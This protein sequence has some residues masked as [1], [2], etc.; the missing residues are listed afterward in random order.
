M[1]VEFNSSR[2]LGYLFL[3]G[4][5]YVCQMRMVRCKVCF[6]V[7]SKERHREPKLDSLV[8]HSSLWKHTFVKPSFIIDQFYSC[9]S[10]RQVKNE[11]LITSI[12][13]D[14]VFDQ[15]QNGGKVERKKIYI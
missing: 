12:R 6:I 13:C 3:L 10:Y 4:R 2:T 14:T 7:E 11:K 9:P 8:K 1:G 15:L 5:T